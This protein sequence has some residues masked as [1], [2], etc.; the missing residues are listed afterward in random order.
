MA[1]AMS[2]EVADSTRSRKPWTARRSPRACFWAR[3]GTST[4]HS[5]P[6]KPVGRLSRGMV[7]PHSTPK[8]EMAADGSIPPSTSLAGM[9]TALAEPSRVPSREVPATGME[10][11]SSW[12]QPTW[13]RAGA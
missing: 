8:A 4:R 11:D 1:G 10:M 7:M 2:R 6:M 13:A 5:A 12:P 3:L 9:S